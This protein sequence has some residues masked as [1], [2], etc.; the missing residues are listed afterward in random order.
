MISYYDIGTVIFHRLWEVNEIITLCTKI[1]PFFLVIMSK[2]FDVQ[3][4]EYSLLFFSQ[5]YVSI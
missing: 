5:I 4:F 2:R 3:M 1:A